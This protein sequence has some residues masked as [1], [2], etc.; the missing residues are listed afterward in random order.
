MSRPQNSFWTLPQKRKNRPKIKLK[1]KAKGE[2]KI[3][4]KSKVRIEANIEKNFFN[5]IYR[6][7]NSF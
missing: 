4:S 2:H 3:R 7:E 5:Y 1:S 6:P